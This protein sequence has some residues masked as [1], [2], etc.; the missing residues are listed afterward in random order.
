MQP[1]TYTENL[2]LY[3]DT[4]VVGV[5]GNPD[6]GTAGNS[7][8][9]SGVHTPPTTGSF[10]FANVRLASATDIFNSAAGLSLFSL[11]KLLHCH[12]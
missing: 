3:G 11:R 12:N 5:P 4:Q 1:G 9:I 2:T 6:S 10:V 8:I 7:V